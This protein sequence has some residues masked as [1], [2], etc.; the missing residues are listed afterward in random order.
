MPKNKGNPFH[1]NSEAAQIH[2][3]KVAGAFSIGIFVSLGRV[4]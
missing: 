2:D 3:L 4:D 1:P